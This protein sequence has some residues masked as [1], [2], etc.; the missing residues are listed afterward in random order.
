MN[1]RAKFTRFLHNLLGKPKADPPLQ[2]PA[3]KDSHE[4]ENYSHEQALRD[5]LHKGITIGIKQSSV[6]YTCFCERHN[7]RLHEV[8]PGVFVCLLCQ[9]GPIPLQQATG[10]LRQSAH[11]QLLAYLEKKNPHPGTRTKELRAIHLQKVR[12]G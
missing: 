5:M 9:T 8:M 1:T 10:P 2:L 7:T 12:Q 6:T 11:P 4:Q 3:P